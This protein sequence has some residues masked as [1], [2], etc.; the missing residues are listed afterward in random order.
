M[1]VRIASTSGSNRRAFTQVEIDGKMY[2]RDICAVFFSHD[3][4]PPYKI[5]LR[6]VYD[7]GTVWDSATA[8]NPPPEDKTEQDRTFE[9]M[10]ETYRTGYE[11]FLTEGGIPYPTSAES[12]RQIR[13]PRIFRAFDRLA[14]H[15]GR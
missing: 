4:R 10:W 7:D 11:K 9:K 13:K 1:L 3:T 12:C 2:G 15:F 8:Q 6:L 5:N 14:R